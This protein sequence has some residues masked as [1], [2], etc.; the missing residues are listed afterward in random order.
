MMARATLSVFV[1]TVIVATFY[2]HCVAAHADRNHYRY[3]N[4]NEDGIDHVVDHH[5]HHD[6]GHFHDHESKGLRQV[7]DR[8]LENDIYDNNNN[9][10]YTISRTGM[11]MRCSI[12]NPSPEMVAEFSRIVP[13]WIESPN[14]SQ[15]STINV[16]R[17]DPAHSK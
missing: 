11:Q 14:S 8:K 17:L 7:R 10:D 9:Y 6:Y 13:M 12:Y 5:Y 2:R 4:T 15:T 3:H 1:L 16:H